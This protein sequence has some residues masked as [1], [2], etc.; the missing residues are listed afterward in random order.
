MN[1]ETIPI[2]GGITI[3]LALGVAVFL[4]NRPRRSNQSFL[5]LSF[6]AIGWLG[7]VYFAV[8]ATDSRR[9]E[10]WIRASFVAA[11]LIPTTLNL[12]RVSIRRRREGCRDILF[13]L[14]IS[15]VP[16]LRVHFLSHTQL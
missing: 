3:Q 7:S 15:L 9:A 14:R 8:T 4:A 5:L 11:A 2:L 6:V 13:R 16:R 1:D 12:L 10:F